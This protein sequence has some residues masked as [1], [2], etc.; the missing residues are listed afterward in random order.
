MWKILGKDVNTYVEGTHWVTRARVP[1]CY[2]GPG[3]ILFSY[4]TGQIIRMKHLNTPCLL[5][6][7]LRFIIFFR[8]P[9]YDAKLQNGN[10]IRV[11]PYVE[12]A[13]SIT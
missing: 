8:K 12:D 11:F 10:I 9:I 4:C 7:I 2:E 13:I 5:F 1:V 6:I 3:I